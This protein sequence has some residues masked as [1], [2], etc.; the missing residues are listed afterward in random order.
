MTL[1]N[2]LQT[3]LNPRQQCLMF[4]DNQWWLVNLRQGIR[5]AEPNDL[6]RNLPQLE[7]WRFKQEIRQSSAYT[8]I[9]T[10]QAHLT[11]WTH[12]NQWQDI[13][14]AI[15][16][17]PFEIA[18]QDWRFRL[19]YTTVVNIVACSR[20][21]SLNQWIHCPIAALPLQ[22]LPLIWLQTSHEQIL[23]IA[24]EGAAVLWKEL[25]E[26]AQPSPICEFVRYDRN[27][28]MSCGYFECP[29]CLKQASLEQD[30]HLSTC[31]HQ[32]ESCLIFHYGRN[33]LSEV[34]DL[35]VNFPEYFKRT[36]MYRS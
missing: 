32:T 35:Q 33:Q 19:Q 11:R 5:L 14:K 25:V 10:N 21:Q 16:P 23:S 31:T 3:Y 30:A 18:I 20:S 6:S 22:S 24:P 26:V 27:L 2:D 13:V 28:T 4:L 8:E 17:L 9:A 12:T 36:K 29:Y 34:D 7:V 15:S 1:S